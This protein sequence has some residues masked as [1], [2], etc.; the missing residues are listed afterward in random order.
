MDNRRGLDAVKVK[1][2]LSLCL[3]F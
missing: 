2:N 1:V 3:F